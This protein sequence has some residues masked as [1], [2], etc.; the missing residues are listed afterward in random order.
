MNYKTHEENVAAPLL[1]KKLTQEQYENDIIMRRNLALQ[2]AQ[3][4]QAKMKRDITKMN[5]DAIQRQ[6][7]QQQFE[8]QNLKTEKQR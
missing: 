3:D 6:V 2:E 8:R 7:A 1:Q 4:R 5:Q